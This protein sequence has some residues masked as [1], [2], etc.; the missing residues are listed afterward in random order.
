M[1]NFTGNL[2]VRSR[3]SNLLNALQ[4]GICKRSSPAN[5]VDITEACQHGKFPAA[6]C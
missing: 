2:E 6:Q 1:I 5:R 4:Y 3:N